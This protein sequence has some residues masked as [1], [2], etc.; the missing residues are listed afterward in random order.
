[1]GHDHV[2]PE[3]LVLQMVEAGRQAAPR[4][5][6]LRPDLILVEGFDPGLLAGKGPGILS[7]HPPAERLEP[8]HG[9]GDPPLLGLL[10]REIRPEVERRIGLDR[11][12]VGRDVA[13]GDM[14]LEPGAAPQPE[15]VL[16]DLEDQAEELLKRQLRVAPHPVGF[17]S[18]GL[19]AHGQGQVGV[20][21]ELAADLGVAE[22]SHVGDQGNQMAVP[23]EAVEEREDALVEERL[24]QDVEQDGRPHAQG[25]KPIQKTI[26][27]GLVERALLPPQDVGRTESAVHVAVAGQLE[28]DRPRRIH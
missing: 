21:E 9:A 26:G 15:L 10:V 6:D 28:K 27:L 14:D 20:A 16:D 17:R 5:G 7:L 2:A 12:I 1:M 22:E 4:D 25:M 19:Q 23:L 13:R 11:G 24:A 8:P 18:R 3:D